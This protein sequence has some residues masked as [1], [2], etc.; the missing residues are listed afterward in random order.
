MVMPPFAK[1]TDK[2][3]YRRYRSRRGRRIAD[4]ESRSVKIRQCHDVVNGMRG[5]FVLDWFP[6]VREHVRV[7]RHFTGVVL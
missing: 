6:H 1:E 7:D 3:F 4:I 5:D 2:M